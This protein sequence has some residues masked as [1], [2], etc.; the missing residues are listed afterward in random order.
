MRIQ[1]PPPGELHD[2]SKFK[3]T[4]GRDPG[5]VISHDRDKIG[6]LEQ[7]DYAFVVF[8]PEGYEGMHTIDELVKYLTKEF[9]FSPKNSRKIMEHGG[10]WLEVFPNN[11]QEVNKLSRLTRPWLKEKDYRVN[12]VGAW[13]TTFVGRYT[14]KDDEYI[15]Y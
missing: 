13:L 1:P 8:I 2:L 10:G 3:H 15:R 6:E 9:C 5:V 11:K 12:S 7:L 14:L 4:C